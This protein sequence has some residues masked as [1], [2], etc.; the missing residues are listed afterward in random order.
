METDLHIFAF[1]D[2][3]V[4]QVEGKLGM[5]G[6][7]RPL[8]LQCLGKVGF[9]MFR[10]LHQ[11]QVVIQLFLSGIRGDVKKAQVKFSLLA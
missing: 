8:V 2:R 3:D 1:P 10:I 9:Q 5:F 11:D 6:D 4:P 7:R